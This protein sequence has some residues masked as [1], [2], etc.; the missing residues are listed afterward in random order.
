MSKNTTKKEGYLGKS[1]FEFRDLKDP[2]RDTKVLMCDHE[3][4]GKLE[5]AY[6]VIGKPTTPQQQQNL[7]DEKLGEGQI[8][9]CVPEECLERMF[10]HYEAIM[11]RRVAL[12]QGGLIEQGGGPRRYQPRLER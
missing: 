11:R 7:E 6:F 5:L 4:G 3:A 12:Q 1:S 2:D 8:M 10:W 9:V